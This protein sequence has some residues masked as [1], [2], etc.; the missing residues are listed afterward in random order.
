M[1][2]RLKQKDILKIYL[3]YE[4]FNLQLEVKDVWTKTKNNLGVD[5][6]S[7]GHISISW[8]NSPN[9]KQFLSSLDKINF[10]GPSNAAIQ[11]SALCRAVEKP[12]DG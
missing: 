4:Y 9:N 2:G 5:I 12:L 7:V 11:W 1:Q 8:V 6:E 10:A 3:H